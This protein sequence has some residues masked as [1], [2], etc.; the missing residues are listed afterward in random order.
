MCTQIATFFRTNIQYEKRKAYA[1]IL[2]K[3]PRLS[4]QATTGIRMFLKDKQNGKTSNP[5]PFSTD[6]VAAK[7]IVSI[8]II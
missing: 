2:S 5:R 3:V 7:G 6:E 1:V 4:L 8:L